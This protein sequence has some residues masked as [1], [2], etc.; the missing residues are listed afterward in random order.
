MKTLLLIYIALIIA[1]TN[2]FSQQCPPAG[3]KIQTPACDSPKNLKAIT[4]CE[5][6]HIKWNGNKEQTY[7]VKATITDPS[8]NEIFEAEA[9]DNSCA[10]NGN[11]SATI[12]VK[13][14]TKVNWKVQSIC[15]INGATFYSPEIEGNETFIPYCESIADNAEKENTDKAIRVYP[16]PTT[17]YL[18]VEYYGKISANMEFRIFDMSGKMVF[19][20]FGNAVANRNNKYQLNLHALASGVYTLTVNNGKDVSKIKVV[21]SGN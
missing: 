19:N 21:L 4:T 3:L 8:T 16:N 20:T 13:Q 7:I 17:G 5:T 14:G 1:C 2:V 11:C 12:Q 15:I 9:T 6:L 10:D 18:T